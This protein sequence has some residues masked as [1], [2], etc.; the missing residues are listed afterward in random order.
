M[1]KKNLKRVVALALT[2]VVAAGSIAL[3]AEAAKKT[4]SRIGNKNRT[5]STG[6][7]FEL[8]VRRNGGISENKIKWT[9]G[10][11]SIVKYDDDDRY[12][13]EMEFRAVKKGTTTIT[14]KNLHT[15]GKISYKITVKSPSNTIS[16][17]GDKSRSIKEGK[18]FELSVRKNGNFDD[19]NLEWVIKD[20]TI[21]RFEDNE[22]HDDEV[23]LVA[24][25]P[26]K[27]TVTCN[28]LITGGKIEYTVTVKKDTS[29]YLISR[30][31]N[32]TKYVEKGDDIDVRVSK[33]SK[34][35]NDQIKWTIS[36]TSILRFEDG[37]N[38]GSE[39]EVEG[40]KTGTVK[41]TAKNLHT[42]GK[43][44]YT[45]KVTRDYDD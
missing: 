32:K 9:I 22:I 29:G 16:R 23:E 25:A 3:P 31:G 26:G 41:L 30:V 27:T 1:M 37:D 10:N 44:V 40:R 28:N 8:E 34:L 13:D 18:E 45:I 12:D 33:G 11:T 20:S 2:A 14:A 36:N 6:S 39:V 35:G 21:V 5:V 19:S 7:E 38:Y 24:V 4:I 42:G 15:G 43:I 17:V